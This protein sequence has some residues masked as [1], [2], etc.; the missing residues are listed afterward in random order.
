MPALN[1]IGKMPATTTTFLLL[2]AL[3]LLG[4]VPAKE[5]T[6]EGLTWSVK[7]LPSG[8]PGPN[9]WGGDNVWLDPG[10][11]LHLHITYNATTGKWDC[12]ELST[13]KQL[14]FGSYQFQVESS[15]DY[16]ANVV[17]GMFFYGSADGV[18]EIDI[19][20]SK[21]G[22]PG[23]ANNADYNVY[24]SNAGI[25]NTAQFWHFPVPMTG[26]FSTQRMAWRPTSVSFWDI[27]GHYAL[28]DTRNV[29]HH[30]EFSPKDQAAV[31]QDPLSM[32]INLWLVSGHAPTNS[33]PVEVVISAFQYQEYPGVMTNK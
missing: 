27:G 23:N 33:Q 14:G 8:G 3:C 6:W 9:S 22:K 7:D 30:W 19:E 1:Y 21:W 12:A 15:L 13:V 24:P 20:Y 26:N 31:P 11:K 25:A 5:L 2:A 29:I 32:H 4:M 18:N 16:D 17:L 28:N 10:G